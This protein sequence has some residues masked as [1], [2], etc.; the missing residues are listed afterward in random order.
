MSWEKEFP[1]SLMVI[2]AHGVILEMNETAANVTYASSG[3]Y[4]L[5]GQNAL[6][7][8]PG[9]ARATLE[10]LLRVQRAHTYTIEKEGRK[11]IVHQMPWFEQGEFAGLVELIFELPGELPHHIRG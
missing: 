10:E 8:H 1:G 11:K 9:P 4:A 7:C 6:D 3:G 5:L 2:D